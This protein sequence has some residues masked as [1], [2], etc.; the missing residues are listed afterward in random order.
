MKDFYLLFRTLLPFFVGCADVYL[1]G[2]FVSVSWSPID[3]TWE[4]RMMS[5]ICGLVFGTMLWV[6]LEWY[7]GKYE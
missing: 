7:R 1:L 4:C 2:S 3:W 6:R 5:V